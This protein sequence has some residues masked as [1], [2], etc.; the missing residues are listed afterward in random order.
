M[1]TR[2][3]VRI[4]GRVQGVNFRYYTR[5]TAQRLN[6]TGWVENAPDG[7]VRGCFEGEDADVHALV[8]WCR[9]GP[10]SAKVDNLHV[11][12]ETFTGEFFDFQVRHG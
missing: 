4:E 1:K 12:P 7:T 9:T 10:P 3:T 11:A 5:Q 6:V 2:V 8:D